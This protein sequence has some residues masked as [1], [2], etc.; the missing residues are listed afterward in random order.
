MSE[1]IGEPAGERGDAWGLAAAAADAAPA[2]LSASGSAT[3]D[4]AGT[5]GIAE[6]NR[7]K[8]PATVCGP[9]LIAAGPLLTSMALK[10]CGRGK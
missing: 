4:I 10:R 8:A 9:Y 7:P 5:P 6:E 1:R 3:S 2:A